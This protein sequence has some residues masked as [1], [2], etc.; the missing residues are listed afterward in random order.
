M[1]VLTPPA[2]HRYEPTV[3]PQSEVAQQRRWDRVGELR[4]RLVEHG[5]WTPV[6]SYLL[7]AVCLPSGVPGTAGSSGAPAVAFFKTRNRPNA[8]N[9]KSVERYR[10]SRKEFEALTGVFSAFDG[11]GN[12]MPS[13]L[14]RLP[15]VPDRYQKILS[16][17]D[18][19]ADVATCSS[20]EACAALR[21][22]VEAHG[23]RWRRRKLL[24][25]LDKREKRL[26]GNAQV[27]NN[28]NRQACAKVDANKVVKL[29]AKL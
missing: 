5:V 6:P 2:P 4:V 10:V 26:A 16:G 9:D 18:L 17:A 29:D 11:A 19:E 24:N 23:E 7:K 20:A 27:D 15:E 1:R 13:S 21:P 14:V 3:F 12:E 22:R 25:I 28:N 8:S